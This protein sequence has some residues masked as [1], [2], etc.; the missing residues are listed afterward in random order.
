[1]HY[2]SVPVLPRTYALDEPMKLERLPSRPLPPAPAVP[3]RPHF[4]E[5]H[6]VRIQDDYAWLKAENW[7]EVL[8]DPE[9]LDSSIRSCLEQENAYT[10]TAFAGSEDFQARLVAEMRGRI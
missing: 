8:K 3:A 6:G 10:A 9:A 2:V 4:F 5:I 7:K 1:M